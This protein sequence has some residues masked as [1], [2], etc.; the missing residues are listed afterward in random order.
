MKVKTTIIILVS[1]FLASWIIG[2]I[3]SAFSNV[4]SYGNVALIPI[5]GTIMTGNDGFSSG[6]S[7][8]WV[9]N[10]ID[11]AN[12]DPSIKAVIFEINSGGGGAV[13]SEEIALAIQRLSK[14][15]VAWVRE[16]AASGAYWA[17]ASTDKIYSSRISI[18]GSVGVFS[19]GI[20][21]SGFMNDH[22]ITY[23]RIVAGKY[24]DIGIPLKEMTPKEEQILQ[25]NIDQIHEYFLD[26][27]A[28]LRNLDN[29][30]REEISSA[31][32]YIG[33]EAL[34][35]GLVD[36]IGTKIDVINY[37]SK[38]LNTSITVKEYAQKE[39]FLET[40]SKLSFPMK[41]FLLDN[42]LKVFT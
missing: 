40:I 9:V 39:S 27:I 19:S 32:I 4:D 11:K 2:G 6:S 20:D 21:V 1:I 34:D 12:N 26:E 8:T 10:Q 5:T 15:S 16:I 33:Q 42:N 31:K 28:R 18:I 17:A 38:D 22:N 24:K 23:N 35:L 7:S 36:E 29:N 3:L 25:S 37:L 13:A 41:N 30:T 14:P